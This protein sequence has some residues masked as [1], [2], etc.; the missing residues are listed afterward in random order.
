M[1]HLR[2]YEDKKLKY[3]VGDVVV[4]RKLEQVRK[5]IMGKVFSDSEY[6]KKVGTIISFSGKDGR[7]YNIED[8]IQSGERIRLSEREIAGLASDKSIKDAE[9]SGDLKK[10]NL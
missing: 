1:K 7:L 9:M 6:V 10:Y 8:L 2:T 3:K 4:Y 5:I